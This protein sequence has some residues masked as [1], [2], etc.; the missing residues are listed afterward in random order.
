MQRLILGSGETATDVAEAARGRP[1]E[2]RVVSRDDGHVEALRESG[3]D[4]TVGDPADPANYPNHADLVV[5][6]ND[7]A[8][9]ADSLIEAVASTFPDATVVA[10]LAPGIGPDTRERFVAVADRVIDPE[11][12]IADR[13]RGVTTTQNAF[14]LRSLLATLRDV[15]EPLLVVTHDNPDPDAIAAALALVNLADRTGVEAEAGYCGDISHQEN[16]ALMNLL[17]IDLRDLD[18]VAVTEEYGAIALVDHSIPGVNDSLPHSVEPAIIVD[19]HPPSEGVDAPFHDIRPEMGSTAAMLTQ[20]VETMGVAPSERV[21]TALLYG[22]RID[23]R[24]FTRGV[25]GGDF[26]AA[27][28]LLPHADAS[29]LDRVESPSISANVF[30]ILATA[31]RD[32]IVENET[33]TSCVGEITDRDA[34]PQAAEKL[35]TMDGVTVAV[36]YGYLDGTVYV[37]GR[38]RGADVDLGET[39]RDAFG[40]VGSAGGHADMAGAQLELGILGAADG[41]GEFREILEQVVSQRVFETLTT[42]SGPT[43]GNRAW[44]LVLDGVDEP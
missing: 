8:D 29:I 14:R 35:L 5:L 18:D 1:G 38:A 3:V 33:V 10:L 23:T 37:S 44:E 19:H 13:V 27:A 21:A 12:E 9:T 7:D 20:Y 4:A 40:E 32:R 25:T 24:D 31:I 28:A 17:D 16:R 26:E 41:D 11:R 34:L 42:S 6:A 22:I 43:E 15:T 30:G 2:T 36:V 39:F